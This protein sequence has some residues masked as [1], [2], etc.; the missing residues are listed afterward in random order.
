MGFHYRFVSRHRVCSTVVGK[1]ELQN[2]PPRGVRVP[3]ALRTLSRSQRGVKAATPPRRRRCSSTTT[4][5]RKRITWRRR[6]RKLRQHETKRRDDRGLERQRAA[7]EVDPSQWTERRLNGDG[8][9]SHDGSWTRLGTSY[10]PSQTS[11]IILPSTKRRRIMPS[12]GL[13]FVRQLLCATEG[14]RGAG[15]LRQEAMNATR[16]GDCRKAPGL[17]IRACCRGGS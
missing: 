10:I 7:A 3:L 17:L 12:L 11:S 15:F 1:V 2:R 13:L 16:R 6:R 4:P 14:R 5:Y 9:F 8:E